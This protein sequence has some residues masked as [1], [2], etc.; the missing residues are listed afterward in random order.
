VT[1]TRIPEKSICNK[2]P[3]QIALS[4]LLLAVIAELMAILWLNSGRFTFTLD[5]PYIHLALGDHIRHGHYGVNANEYSSPSSSILWP[6]LIAPFSHWLVSPYII[7]TM[8]IIL[9]CLTIIVYWKIL[10]PPP[11]QDLDKN[12]FKFLSLTLIV[13]IIVTNLVGLI[14]T[15]MEHSFQ[16]LS[17]AMILLGLIRETEK[18]KLTWW[19]IAAI[20]IAPLIRYEG[21]ALSLPAATFLFLRGYRTPALLLGTF[22]MVS[23]GLFSGFL[24]SLG[25]HPLPNSI[26]AKSIFV[27]SGGHAGFLWLNFKEGLSHVT[28]FLVFMALL[29]L[30]VSI[31]FKGRPSE[32]K[33]L[34]GTLVCSIVL[35]LLFGQYGWYGRYEIYIWSVTLLVF[36]YLHKKKFYSFSNN[37]DLFKSGGILLLSAILFGF[38]YFYVFATTPIGANNIYEQQYQMHRFT[39]EYYKK[40]VAVNDLGYVVYLNPSYVL[41]LWGLASEESLRNRLNGKNIDWIA[42]IAQEKGV[43]LVMIYEDAFKNIPVQWR[44]VGELHLGKT[45]ITPARSTV[46]FFALNNKAYDEIYGLALK[47][48]KTLPRGVKF[49]LY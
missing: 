38:P 24:V 9:S 11:T 23:L 45:R 36:L 25:L 14:F 41:D 8:N 15:G 44:K 33:I 37:T 46:S 28:G 18:R 43:E 21:L 32:D 12:T 40:P 34:A 20:A 16:V 19:F 29:M 31:L 42:T 47:F 13:L 22:I 35:H 30:L 4:F 10:L 1:I 7:L 17:A 3:L 39:T 48:K 49:I 27:G 5:D 6:F 2:K 26:M